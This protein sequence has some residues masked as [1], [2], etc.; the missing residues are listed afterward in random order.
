MEFSGPGRQYLKNNILRYKSDHGMIQN[1]MDFG[2]AVRA[3]A[4]NP[5]IVMCGLM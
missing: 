2:V 4:F 1:N 5:E 3:S